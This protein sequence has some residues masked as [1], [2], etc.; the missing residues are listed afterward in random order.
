MITYDLPIAFR[1]SRWVLLTLCFGLAAAAFP[2]SLMAAAPVAA[3]GS[4]GTEPGEAVTATLSATD[5]DSDPLTYIITT[6]PTKGSLSVGPTTLAAGNLPYTIPAAGNSVVYSASGTAHGVDTFQFKAN[7]GTAD[8]TAATVTVVVNRGPVA[9]TTGLTTVPN[10]DLD[11]TLPASDPDNDILSYTITSL[12]GHGRVKS[13]ATTLTDT[14]I[15]FTTTANKL[16]YTPDTDY[17]GLDAFEFIASDTYTESDPITVEIQINTV[18]VP[19]NQS[20]TLLPDTSLSIQLTATEPDK[21]PLRYIIA[22]LPAHGTLS[23]GQTP[24]EE[25]QLPRLLD[26]GV[27]TVLY[28]VAPGYRGTDSFHFRVLDE[29]S[30]SDRAV[31]TLAVNTPPVS[32]DSAVSG[33]NSADITGILAPT[34]EDGDTLTIQLTALPETGTLKINGVAGTLTDTYAAAA[35]APAFTFTYTPEPGDVGT[36][37]FT[38]TANDGREDSE[39]AEVTIALL[40]VSPSGDGDPA[41]GDSSSGSSAGCGSFGAGGL[42]LLAAGLLLAPSRTLKLR[43]SHPTADLSYINK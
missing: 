19:D 39:P 23:V 4:F 32:P 5:S 3:A 41:D 13:G 27:D 40:A 14:T 35:T 20:L 28:A 31:V 10:K 43:F 42:I 21:D 9:G 36:E 6:L 17:H 18:P 33:F 2:S 30:G 12:P 34:D 22:S 1:G 25:G 37:T 38:W 26:A 24:I 7:D 15:P 11:I 16:T 8:S 29:V